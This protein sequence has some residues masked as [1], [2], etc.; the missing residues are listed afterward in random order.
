MKMD[1]KLYLLTKK[2]EPLKCGIKNCRCSLHFKG[3]DPFK[4][5]F[6]LIDNR[7]EHDNFPYHQHYALLNYIIQQIVNI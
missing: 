5:S 3:L 1:F 4:L 2:P 7:F 6:T